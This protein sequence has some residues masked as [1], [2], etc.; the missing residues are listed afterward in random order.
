MV[1][2][3]PEAAYVKGAD[4]VNARSNKAREKNTPPTNIVM[5]PLVGEIEGGTHKQSSP[6]MSS[7]A[8][9]ILSHTQEADVIKTGYALADGD[10]H[11]TIAEMRERPDI[12]KEFLWLIDSARSLAAS[13][14][15]QDEESANGA[16]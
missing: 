13:V 1:G 6:R 15:S 2:A 7:L 4:A 11:I 10:E 9:K 14:L 5:V 8:S 16:E 3:I 12:F